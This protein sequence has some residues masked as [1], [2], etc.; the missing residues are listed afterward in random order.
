MECIK[1]GCSVYVCDIGEYLHGDLFCDGN[2]QKMYF[3]HV[4]WAG[5]EPSRDVLNA[6]IDEDYHWFMRGYGHHRSLM[7]IEDE[8]LVRWR[9]EG[10]PVADMLPAATESDDMD[11]TTDHDY[12]YEVIKALLQSNPEKSWNPD[13][14]Q[15]RLDTPGKYYWTYQLVRPILTRLQEEGFAILSG[16]GWYKYTG[17]HNVLT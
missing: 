5:H 9:Q 4:C 6:V 14:I 8:S 10:E 1:T 2:E 13:R 3:L 17:V 15:K 7:V 16:N 12:D 11:K